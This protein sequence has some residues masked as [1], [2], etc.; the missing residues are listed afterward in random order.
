[1]QKTISCGN[2]AIEL[3]HLLINNYLCR[4]LLEGFPSAN[5]W[6]RSVSEI[7]ILLPLYLLLL[8]SS[9]HRS[10]HEKRLL[11]KASTSF[12]LYSCLSLPMYKRRL[13][14]STSGKCNSGSY[15]DD[16]YDDDANGLMHSH[17]FPPVKALLIFSFHISISICLCLKESFI[18]QRA[19]RY[20]RRACE[21][22]SYL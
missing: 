14:R 7:C 22:N 18:F 12:R 11:S 6:L 2:T 13:K 21:Q 15:G 4:H 3:R 16:N 1:M 5:S 9:C 17:I 8:F 19:N 20:I 10:S